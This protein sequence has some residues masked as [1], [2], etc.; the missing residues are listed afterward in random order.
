[1]IP[2]KNAEATLGA[3]LHALFEQGDAPP[4]EIIVA[5]NGSTDGSAALAE[6]LSSQAPAGVQVVVVDCSARAGV[7]AAR[8]AGVAHSRADLILICDADDVV[9]PQWVREMA[10]ALETYDLVG[11]A[12]DEAPLNTDLDAI[13]GRH[14]D[15]RLPVSLRFL[16]FALGANLGGHKKVIEAIGGW[17]EGFVGG[18]DDID[19][20]WRA[21]LAGYTLGFASTAVIA[22]RLRKDLKGAYKQAYRNARAGPKLYR[23]YRDK[24]ACRRTTRSIVYS[25]FWLVSRAPAL[26]FGDHGLRLLWCRRMGLAAGRVSGSVTNRVVYL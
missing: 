9:S 16:P 7:S 22:Y 26:A 1:V 12:L 4:F 20:S 2:T 23:G 24:G 14:L 5:D 19:F 8:N 17:D 6:S 3:Q 13:N 25:W 11:G 21:Q 10:I 18:G 15:E